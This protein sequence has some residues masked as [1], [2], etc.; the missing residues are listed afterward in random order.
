[1]PEF[2]PLVRRIGHDEKLSEVFKMRP[3]DFRFAIHLADHHEGRL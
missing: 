3:G 2:D 1:M